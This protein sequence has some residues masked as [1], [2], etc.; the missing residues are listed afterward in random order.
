MDYS[1]GLSRAF[2]V[3]CIIGARHIVYLAKLNEVTFSVTPMLTDVVED[4]QLVVSP[5]PAGAQLKEFDC[6]AIVSDSRVMRTKLVPGT[7]PAWIS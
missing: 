6:R 2:R 3:E 7:R 1:G 4:E 5:L